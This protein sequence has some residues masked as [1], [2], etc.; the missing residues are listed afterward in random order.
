MNK[1]SGC[2]ADDLLIRVRFSNIEYR[3]NIGSR[4]FMSASRR[5]RPARHPGP[6]VSL[7]MIRPSCDL[8]EINESHRVQILISEIATVRRAQLQTLA[9]Q[10]QTL[11]L[12]LQTLALQLQP[13]VSR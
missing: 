7:H 9:L 5:F 4:H 2:R 13:Q 11:A 8:L 3:V 10:L 12:Q 1:V 6:I